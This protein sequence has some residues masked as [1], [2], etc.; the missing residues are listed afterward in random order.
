MNG[1]RR[2]FFGYEARGAPFGPDDGTV[3]PWA[4]A[5]SLPFAPEIVI[6]TMRHAIERLASLGRSP[7]GL[8]ASYNPTYPATDGNLHAWASPCIFGLNE[9]PILMMI[10]NFHMELILE[11]C[12]A[13]SLHRK[14]PAA[15]RVSR[16]LARPLTISARDDAVGRIPL[17]MHFTCANLA[18]PTAGG[19]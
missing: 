7:Y 6:K 11:D 15:R 10:E 5:T 12:P 9:G 1:V 13:L 16:R 3:S 19:V 2:E 17:R 18:I 8:V 14:G 4:V